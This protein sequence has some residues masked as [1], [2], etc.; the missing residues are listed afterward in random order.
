MWSPPHVPRSALPNW[1]QAEDAWKVTPS[2]NINANK[3]EARSSRVDCWIAFFFTHHSS[4]TEHSQDKRD[5][6]TLEV[7]TPYRDRRKTMLSTSV[8]FV[9]QKDA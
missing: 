7:P 1:R 2:R 5:K 4:P 6:L 3:F 8:K 9:H